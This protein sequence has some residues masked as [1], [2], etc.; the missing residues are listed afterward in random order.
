[1]DQNPHQV[2]EKKRDTLELVK[3]L[4]ENKIDA[5]NDRVTRVKEMEG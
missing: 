3:Q 5:I 4:L 1:M 2:S